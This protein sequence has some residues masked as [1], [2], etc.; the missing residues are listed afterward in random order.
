M[1]NKKLNFVILGASGFIA[2]SLTR[3]LSLKDCYIF[4][5][6]RKPVLNKFVNVDYQVIERYEDI[7]FPENAI[8]FHLAETHH[9]SSVEVQGILYI[10][11]MENLT[12]TLMGKS[13]SRFI[14]ASSTVVYG[15]QN[16]IPNDTDLE[17]QFGKS[18]YSQAK[19]SVEK[20]VIE[21]GGVVA[22]IT[23]I[24][25]IGMSELN[26]FA[27]ILRQLNN[28]TI[29]IRESSPI[30]DY[31]YI[32]DLVNGLYFMSLGEAKGIFNLAS[33]EAVSCEDLCKIILTTVNKTFIK[34]NFLLKPRVSIIRVDI[35]RTEEK[36]NWH[37]IYTLKDGIKKLLENFNGK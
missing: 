18:I 10:K 22:R 14:Y 33:G 17:L 5:F 3:F 23:N 16:Q 19:Q 36:F 12:K 1:I 9:I 8:V 30:R 2:Q 15:D 28:D 31:L 13:F 4:C 34:L 27:D 7:V 29:T 26:I 21:N 35:S 6:S 24:Y 25:G 32:D 37:P 11:Q 20:I